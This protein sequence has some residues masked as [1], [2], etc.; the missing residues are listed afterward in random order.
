M[1]TTETLASQLADDC[2]KAMEVTGND[3]LHVEVGKVL[4]ASS[5]TLEEA[6]LTEMRVRLAAIGAQKFLREQLAQAQV[7]DT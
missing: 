4:G 6:F 5:Q 2:M 3:R 7:R 1:G